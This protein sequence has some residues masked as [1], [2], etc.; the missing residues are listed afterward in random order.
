MS[1]PTSSPTP[2]RLISSG[3]VNSEL[4][5]LIRRAVAAGFGQAVRDALKKLAHVLSVYPQYG[6]ARR[7]LKTVGQT[8]YAATFPPLHVD[9]IVDE[10]RRLVFMV[11]RSG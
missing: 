2:Y 5:A 10:P 8:T 3:R 1:Q 11:A 4:K 9:Y 7:V 6:E